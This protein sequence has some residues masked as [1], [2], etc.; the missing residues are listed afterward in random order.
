M[1]GGIHA[2]VELVPSPARPNTVFLIEPFSFA[3]CLEAGAVDQEMQW[4]SAVDV[5]RQYGQTAAS[6]AECRMIRYGNGDTEYSAIE[7][8]SPSV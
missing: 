1:R 7:R 6:P 8:S 5:F 4:L 2:E 3:I